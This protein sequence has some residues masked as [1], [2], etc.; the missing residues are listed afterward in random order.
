MPAKKPPPKDEK[1][2]GERFKEAARKAEVDPDQFE[3]VMGK[4]APPKKP[5]R[6]PAS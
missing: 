1:P 6:P 2:Q 5:R 4:I 3:R